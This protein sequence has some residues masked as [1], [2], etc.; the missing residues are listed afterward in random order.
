M[1]AYRVSLQIGCGDWD[2]LIAVQSQSTAIT[3][4][5]AAHDDWGE[6]PPFLVYWVGL[7][8]SFGMD[9]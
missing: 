9:K 5:R 6:Q 4:T 2:E 8:R 7:L 3:A 1:R